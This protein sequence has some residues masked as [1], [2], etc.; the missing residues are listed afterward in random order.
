[1]EKITSTIL[2]SKNH[3]PKNTSFIND[4][5]RLSLART[6]R[7]GGQERANMRLAIYGAIL[8]SILGLSFTVGAEDFKWYDAKKYVAGIKIEQQTG[9][10]A[11]VTDEGKSDDVIVKDKDVSKE[12]V[13]TI[14]V[15][16]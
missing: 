15:E 13:A 9:S 8:G 10:Q 5:P 4:L 14:D 16:E 1:M 2:P 12:D 3:V 11:V 6:L 7:N